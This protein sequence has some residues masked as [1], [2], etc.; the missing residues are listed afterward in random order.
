MCFLY[1]DHGVWLEEDSAIDRIFQISDKLRQPIVENVSEKSKPI[2]ID[3]FDA[4]CDE[5]LV[6]WHCRKYNNFL[7]FIDSFIH[8]SYIINSK[9]FFETLADKEIFLV[10]IEIL[11][12]ENHSQE[13]SEFIVEHEDLI[14]TISEAFVHFSAI[15]SDFVNYMTNFDALP[16][17]I[18]NFNAFSS[19][20]KFK[21][22]KFLINVFAYFDNNYMFS[23]ITEIIDI[24]VVLLK[25]SGEEN[26][27]E[28]SVFLLS[29][30]A[31][32]AKLISEENQQVIFDS[33]TYVFENQI[34][35][36]VSNAICGLFY[37][38][39]SNKAI[40][41][42]VDVESIINASLMYYDPAVS[43]YVMTI[44]KLAFLT[45]DYERLINLP[46]LINFNTISNFMQL[47]CEPLQIA[48]TTAFIQMINVDNSFIS[49][50]IE[51]GVYEKV[52]ETFLDCR[53]DL[54]SNIVDFVLMSVDRSNQEQV[55]LLLEKEVF[56]VIIHT[57]QNEENQAEDCAK[58]LLNIADAFPQVLC[59]CEPFGELFH[60]DFTNE[61]LSSDICRLYEIINEYK[62]DK[63]FIAE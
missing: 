4:I 53:Y 46:N 8:Y 52:M 20:I 28:S 17:I 48:T 42:N 9:E 39:L 24:A 31:R 55:E 44:I 57:I 63:D 45:L 34:D 18:D 38:F 5:F 26:A 1:K 41:A 13:F 47:D 6:C 27:E 54:K 62:A 19:E 37:L 21:M 58:T 36:C 43:F 25:T 23:R 60:T 61:N 22:L 16:I 7:E 11:D 15:S 14:Q 56:L 40:I 10:M 30:I 59:N 49:L 12:Y 33:L 32:R 35:H 51:N 50:F 3:K 2:I 29:N